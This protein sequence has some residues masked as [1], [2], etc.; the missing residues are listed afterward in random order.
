MEERTPPAGQT[1]L[2]L[3][4]ALGAAGLL[5]FGLGILLARASGYALRP[6]VILLGLTVL[7]CLHLAA[8]AARGT[9]GAAVPRWPLPWEWPP[10]R[11]RRLGRGCLLLA[12]ALGLWLQAGAGTGRLT[13]PLGGLGVVCS[14][15]LFAPP[16]ALARRGWGEAAAALGFGLLPVFAGYYLQTGH[17]LTEILLLGLP[18]SL[19]AF[20]LFL[21]WGLPAPGSLPGGTLAARLSPPGVGLLFTVVNIFTI[22]AL[23]VVLLFPAVPLPSRGGLFLLLGWALVHQELIKRRAYVREERLTLLARLLLLKQL[24]MGLVFVWGLWPRL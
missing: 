17:G 15:C 20:N 16:L 9:Y 7:V 14:H 18:L 5:P 12:A 24:A 2:A 11:W 22:A 6:G 8:W 21:I 4:L 10:A 3:N 19:A 1:R 23:C 13:L